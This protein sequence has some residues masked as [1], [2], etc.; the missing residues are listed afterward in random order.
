MLVSS[1]PLA[2]NKKQM[3]LIINELSKVSLFFCT[4]KVTF[5]NFS[6]HFYTF[7]QKNNRLTRLIT[8]I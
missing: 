5:A 2:T 8:K 3:P 1:L 4:V 7:R 6:R